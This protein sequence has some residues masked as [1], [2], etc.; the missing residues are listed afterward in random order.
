VELDHIAW[1]EEEWKTGTL[2][3]P[4][5]VRPVLNFLK[6]T[7]ALF[8]EMAATLDSIRSAN[9]QISDSKL[10]DVVSKLKST[11]LEERGKEANYLKSAIETLHRHNIL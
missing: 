9:G 4:D 2:K 8:I 3:I 11:R 6:T 10:L 5:E 1:S 7:D